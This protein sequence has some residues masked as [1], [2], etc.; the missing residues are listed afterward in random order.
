MTGNYTVPENIP[1]EGLVLK[2]NVSHNP[3]VGVWIVI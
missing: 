3:T 2:P 1:A